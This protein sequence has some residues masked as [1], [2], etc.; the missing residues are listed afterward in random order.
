VES[1]GRFHQSRAVVE[2]FSSRTLAA[3]S[4]AL[5]RL[6]YVSSSRDSRS[7][8]YVH[9]GLASL[10]SQGAIQE[11]LIHCHQE[12]FA[13][14]LETP[15]NEQGL[16][17]NKC[18]RSSGDGYW[19]TMEDWRENLQF[20]NLCPEEAPEYLHDLFCSNMSALLAILASNKPN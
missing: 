1:L 5:G 14:I 6:Y 7:G 20:R 17:L 4:S 11:G 3:I 9:D 18:L 13:K 15:L 2:D 16:D 8:R 12:L 10:Y 19:E